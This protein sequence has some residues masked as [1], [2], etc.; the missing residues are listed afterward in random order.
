MDTQ[1]EADLARFNQTPD[2]YCPERI[3]DWNEVTGSP[4]HL[5]CSG[6]SDWWNCARPCYSPD[7]GNFCPSYFSTSE[8]EEP[9]FER[10]FDAEFEELYQ[11][12]SKQLIRSSQ[13]S[14]SS[15]SSSASSSSSS[16]VS[17]SSSDESSET[18]SRAEGQEIRTIGLLHGIPH[19]DIS[20]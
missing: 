4:R 1:L 16:S 9:T 6:H 2:P 15:S 14:T 11:D 19:Y 13:C 20:F 12:S 10:T 17:N 7:A 3:L 5:P 18:E 8:V